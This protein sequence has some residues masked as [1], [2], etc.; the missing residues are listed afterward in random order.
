MSTLPRSRAILGVRVDDVTYEETLEFCRQCIRS[1]KPHLIVTLNTEF[2]VSAQKDARFKDLINTAALSVPDGGGLLLAGRLLGFPLREQ[3]RGTDL[4]ERLAQLCAQE[5][6][7]LF[8]LG[9]A[10]GVAAGR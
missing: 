2:V 10:E 8:L 7:R 6:Y 3:V 4:A 1:G 9:A 5:G